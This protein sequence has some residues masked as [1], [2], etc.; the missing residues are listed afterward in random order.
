MYGINP[1]FVFCLCA[2]GP[3][4][5]HIRFSKIDTP[6]DAE[7]VSAVTHDGHQE[8]VGFQ[9]HPGSTV[10]PRG[11]VALRYL[12]EKFMFDRFRPLHR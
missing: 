2:A 5:S 4:K 10:A 7:L 11:L 12:R 6:H 9:S 1:D 3:E 8:A